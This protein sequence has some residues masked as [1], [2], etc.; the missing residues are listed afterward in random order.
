MSDFCV[1]GVVLFVCEFECLEWVV[2]GKSVWD[3][4]CI[5]GILYYIVIFYLNNVKVKLGVWI[6]V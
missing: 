2:C 6:V 1:D 3:I 5:L 4:G